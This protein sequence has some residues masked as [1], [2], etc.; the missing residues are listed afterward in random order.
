[1]K[2]ENEMKLND[3]LMF[4]FKKRD[5]SILD[6]FET[7]TSNDIDLKEKLIKNIFNEKLEAIDLCYILDELCM[8]YEVYFRFYEY[9]NL[10]HFLPSRTEIYKEYKRLNFKLIQHFGLENNTTLNMC[11]ISLIN[12]LKFVIRASFMSPGFKEKVIILKANIDFSKIGNSTVFGVQIMNNLEFNTQN[13]KDV[14][15]QTI[16]TGKDTSDSIKIQL[17]KTKKEIENLKSIKII[18]HKR[19]MEEWKIIIIWNSDLNALWNITN[20]LSLKNF[21]VLYE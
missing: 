16:Y 20:K 2:N 1:L 7:L 12:Y 13:E 4:Y 11:R 10:N 14:N 18:N 5:V 6:Y 3:L 9:L 17:E 21:F 19:E 8:S 15:F